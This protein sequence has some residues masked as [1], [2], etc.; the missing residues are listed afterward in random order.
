MGEANTQVTTIVPGSDRRTSSRRQRQPTAR[1][2]VLCVANLTPGKGHDILLRALSTVNSEWVLV[3]AGSAERD[4]RHAA[5]LRTLADTLG[6]SSRVEWVGELDEVALEAQY[7]D[8]DLFVL[9]TRAETYGMAVAEAISHGVPVV[10][11]RTGEIP[12][13]VGDGGVLAAPDDG[14]D[15]RAALDAVLNDPALCRKLEAGARQAAANLPTWDEAA[16]A[17]ADVLTR[18]ARDE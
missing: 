3:C 14:E 18:V 2:R 13:I 12:S 15:F 4:A 8:A 17:I 10:S 7:R 1:V 9:P 6:V 11:T 16:E 5:D